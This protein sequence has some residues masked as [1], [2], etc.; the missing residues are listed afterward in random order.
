MRILHVVASYLPAV[1]YGGTIVSVHGLC[2]ALAARGHDVHVFTTS[3]DGPV[4]SPVPIATPVMLD[5]VTVW[6]F[7]SRHLRRLYWA[8]ALGEALRRRIRDFDVLHTH[9]IYLWPLWAAA[10]HAR[11]AGVPYVVSPRGML[12]KELIES[13]NAFWK[14]AVIGFI[15]HRN[16]EAAAAIHV[17]S[18]READGALKFGFNLPPLR[19]IPNG[20]ELG[21]GAGAEPSPVIRALGSAAPFVLFLGR[22]NWKKGIDRLIAALAFAP[23]L[24]LVLAGNDEDGEWP[25]L[26]R[27]AVALGV[28][29]RVTFV[30][31]V[32]GADKAAILRMAAVL[33]LPSYSENFGN[34][35]LEAMAV[36]CPVVV[37]PEVG[38]AE[39]V[40]DTNAGWV[41]DGKPAVLGA[42]LDEIVSSPALRAEAG[43]RGRAAVV[44]SFTWDRV[45]QQMEGVY[46]EAIASATGGHP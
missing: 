21:S 5:G 35:V 15:E 27:R 28:A 30:G 31:P 33:V 2:K 3:V 36:G 38:I 40:A 16:L 20:V 45:A 37:T 12:E 4:D 17:T 11:A 24:R 39:V 9:A 19:K 18:Q 26:E 42:K 34:V 6:Y 13:K 29:G 1:R 8:P 32:H 41:V 7:Q 23:A 43:A 44:R 46:Q 14:A 25:I 22:I 10:R